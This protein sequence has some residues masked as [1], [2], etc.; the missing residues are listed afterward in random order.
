[1]IWSWASSSLAGGSFSFNS[2]NNTVRSHS[3]DSLALARP[4]RIRVD[5]NLFLALNLDN[6]GIMDDDFHRP[7]T[8]ILD[9]EEDLVRNV[10]VLLLAL[11]QLLLDTHAQTLFSGH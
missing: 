5:T 2:D 4:R 3:L 8:K 11:Y 9:C 1:M 7:E 6:P 10:L